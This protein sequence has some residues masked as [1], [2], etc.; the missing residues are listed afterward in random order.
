LVTIAFDVDGTLQISGGPIPIGRLKELKAKG[1]AVWIVGNYG[2]IVEFRLQDT[3]PNGNP[4][5]LPKH[6]ALLQLGGDF[7]CIYVG[8]TSEDEVAA[9]TAGWIFCWAK[10][11]R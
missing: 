10:N 2:K 4:R 6:E 5:G 9:K 8:D 11:F 1:V 3:F 7:L